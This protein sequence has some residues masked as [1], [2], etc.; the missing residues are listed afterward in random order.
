ME[1]IVAGCLNRANDDDSTF[2]RKTIISTN[3]FQEH[4]SEKPANVPTEYFSFFS[5]FYIRFFVLL[6]VGSTAANGEEEV[7]R[8]EIIVLATACA[9]DQFK[10]VL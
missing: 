4:E 6:F 7:K 10:I 3:K 8:L 2:A 5:F 1:R 9:F